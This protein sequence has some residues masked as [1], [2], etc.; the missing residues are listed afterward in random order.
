MENT[1]ILVTDTIP[2]G[3][4]FFK[5]GS[6]LPISVIGSLVNPYT[7]NAVGVGTTIQLDAL[8][9]GVF[10]QQVFINSDQFLLDPIVP[11]P[12]GLVLT[13]INN[14]DPVGTVHNF[15]K[16]VLSVPELPPGRM[17]TYG[18]GQNWMAL[19]DGV[20]FIASD[21]V[22]S[23]SG[24]AANN[25]RDAVLRTVQATS[26]GGLGNF[27]VPGTVGEIRA[28]SFVA[29]LDV[30]LGQG[31]LQIFTA[32]SA[33]SCKAPISTQILATLTTPI[34]AE[35]LKGSGADG[36]Y[37]LAQDNADIIFGSS[38]NAVRSLVLSRLDFDKWSN[39]PISRE[40]QRILDLNNKTL[41][42][43][44]T[45]AVFNNRF[46]KSQLPT[47]GLLGVYHQGIAVL[48]FDPISSIRGKAPSVWDGFWTGL[49][50]FQI[51]TGF[52]NGTARCY[53]FCFNAFTSEIELWEM[54]SDTDTS[55]DN[56]T[57]PIV[58]DFESAALFNSVKG[59]GKYDPCE[60][61]DGELYI[62]D[63]RGIVNIQTWYRPDY[64]ECWTPWHE[65]TICAQNPA[66]TDPKQ[67][68]TRL[69]LGTPDV[70]A[71]EPTN[72]HPYRIGRSFQ[73]RMQI[74]G[75][76]T[77]MG[78]LFKAKPN[79]ETE[80]S[81]PICDPLCSTVVEGVCEPC[82][83]QLPCLRF[84]PVFY[85]LGAG[86]TYSNL[87]VSFEII[88]PDGS[89]KLVY[90]Q[91]GVI[92]FT[93]PY[94]VGYVG[95]YPPLVLGC[96][97]G[98]IVRAVPPGATQEIFDAIVEEMI[99]EC[100]LAIAT[101]N[102]G[103]G[104]VTFTNEEVR[105][106]VSC[107]DGETLT[108][109]STLP[110][111]ITIDTGTNEL[112]GAAGVFTADTK[113]NATALAQAA[114]N[115]FAAAAITAGTLTCEVPVVPPTIVLVDSQ[116]TGWTPGESA[117]AFVQNGG[118]FYG[119]GDTNFYSS[120]NGVNWTNM[121]A[122][123]IADPHG[124]AFGLGLFVVPSSFPN[125][126]WSSPDGLTWTAHAYAG[127]ATMD[128]V[129]FGGGQ[130]VAVGDPGGQVVTSVNGTAWTPQTMGGTHPRS[131][132]FGA[133]LY[134]A[135]GQNSEVFS[136]PDGIVWTLQLNL[137]SGNF[138]SIEFVNGLFL[139]G[140]NGGDLYTSANGTAWGSAGP[141]GVDQN[142]SVGGGAG[143]YVVTNFS[144]EVWTSPDSTTWTLFETEAGARV[145]GQQ[146]ADY[147]STANV[148]NI[149]FF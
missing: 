93:L 17:G 80:F 39:A 100:A 77:F 10:N 36:Q 12:P 69:G 50:V 122:H 64:S 82:K 96:I 33:F 71:C 61:L 8:Y 49:N 109:S 68:R 91:P 146:S 73:F 48:N 38:D 148:I 21:S 149:G 89:T 92:K 139:V 134:V 46:L 107:A 29:M 111:W 60:L 88:C 114:L 52:V 70:S 25:Y 132:A 127:G 5:F 14:N 19:T 121:G 23:S 53:A 56:V 104:P 108:Y 26:V 129:C 47:N 22:G 78:A 13:A 98:N 123:G 140:G 18:L 97:G 62:R 136:S 131:V 74:T 44:G 15:P 143:L 81:V 72:N 27:R 3:N 110:S 2:A 87:L 30:S 4:I 83:E 45:A 35:S 101:A 57:T 40:V 58:W 112:V 32:V 120:I 11:P 7:A 116:T 54:E 84:D 66:L 147:Y 86:K 126:M 137:A 144:G 6:N 85:N 90:V 118:I 67:F 103:C 145:P 41:L 75:S 135:C 63:I 115:S 55:F 95:V 142:R 76:C 138:W 94:P 141:V 37:D 105:F 20:S 133:G 106:A 31:P 24:T 102:A 28:M 51:I 130:F 43:F 9:A 34:V 125:R 42:Q 128:S 59:K 1:T 119:I 16:D 65:F 117:I 99:N 113:E 79:P 124:L